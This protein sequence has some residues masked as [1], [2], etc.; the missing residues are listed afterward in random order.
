[1]KYTDVQKSILRASKLR[2]TITCLA[3]QT[4]FRIDSVRAIGYGHRLGVKR[5]DNG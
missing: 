5:A 3:R 2:P 4:C 1:M